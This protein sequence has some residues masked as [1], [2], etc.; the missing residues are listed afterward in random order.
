MEAINGTIH[1]PCVVSL[2]PERAERQGKVRKVY[3]GTDKARLFT[4]L[5]EGLL[6][7]DVSILGRF[8]AGRLVLVLLAEADRP[9]GPLFLHL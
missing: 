2:I 9:E 6:L 4:H 7:S 8:F 5:C 3:G 1:W